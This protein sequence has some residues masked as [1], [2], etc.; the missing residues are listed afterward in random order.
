MCGNILFNGR[1]FSSFIMILK[2][3]SIM[4]KALMLL[5]LIPATFLFARELEVLKNYSSEPRL[6]FFGFLAVL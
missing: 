6:P 5:L 3:K 2:G 4:R 1:Y